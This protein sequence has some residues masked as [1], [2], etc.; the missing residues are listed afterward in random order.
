MGTGYNYFLNTDCPFNDHL[1]NCFCHY[2]CLWG[3]G[4]AEGSPSKDDGV[5]NK[6]LNRLADALKR[7]VGK[8]VEALPA[9]V[10]SIVGVIL[11]FSGKAVGFVAEHIWV[12]IVFV[13]GRIAVWLMQRV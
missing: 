5:L 3:R 2:R 6:W 7:L 13:A 12:L 10:G 8:A 9:I 11:S 1:N 4:R